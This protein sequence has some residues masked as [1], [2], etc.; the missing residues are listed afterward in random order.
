[1]RPVSESHRCHV[2]AMV[3]WLHSWVR[4]ENKKTGDNFECAVG[5]TS[6]IIG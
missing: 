1:M 3:F 5:V 4:R 2:K 6:S